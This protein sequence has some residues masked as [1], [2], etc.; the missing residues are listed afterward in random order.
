MQLIGCKS[1]KAA[2]IVTKSLDAL[3][4]IGAFWR[5]SESNT[6]VLCFPPM[7]HC[8]I[9]LR[10]HYF[11]RS[12]AYLRSFT[13][14]FSLPFL[15]YQKPKKFVP[16]VFLEKLFGW[17]K[18]S[19][20]QPNIRFGRYSDAYKTDEQYGFWDKAIELFEQKRYMDAYRAFFDYL[21]DENED[22]VR[23]SKSGD[24]MDFEFFQGSKRITGFATPKKVVAE[25]KVARCEKLLVAFM[26][27]LM[28][29]NYNL[30]YTRFALNDDFI[31]IK[32]DTGTLDGS[33]EKLYYALKELA[34]RA[35]KQ[36]DLLVNEFS[37]LHSIN[38]AHIEQL[39]DGE[40][41]I[42]LRFMSKW[43]AEIL[44]KAR[45]LDSNNFSGGIGYMLL[46]LAYKIDYLIVPE[47]HLMD[48]IEKLHGT[49]FLNDGA[50]VVEKNERL[51]R[52]F[53]SIA[54]L[55]PED[56]AK[57]LYTVVSTFGVSSP[58]A[59]QQI[60]H[61]LANELQTAKGY[62]ENKYHNTA[63]HILEYMAQYSMFHFGMPKP[64]R[65]LLHI[66]I[67]VMNA[68]FFQQLGFTQLPYK[69]DNQLFDK[70]VIKKRLTRIEKSAIKRYPH[71]RI[72]AGQLKYSSINDF[73]YSMYKM[74]MHLNYDRN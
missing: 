57:E 55:K 33:P 74:M 62:R 18:E 16:L 25:T 26:R 51:M 61:F 21:H 39:P 34:I 10:C 28:E 70:S 73:A 67:E 8:S 42:K 31:C 43:I 36:D 40:K 60:A 53:H 6:K 2:D 30:K 37:V 64:T 44:E 59:P 20:T 3:N 41:D 24:R 56:V 13:L 35:D 48:K 50:S 38:D 19:T 14:R 1:C 4:G 54:N 9:G 72:S 69:P 7:E 49:Y 12:S 58:T 46:N 65:A 27:Q 52:E 29:L 71:F 47:G 66:I 11:Y 22:N 15:F 17:G 5:L 45:S 32:F 68:G 63:T 23:F